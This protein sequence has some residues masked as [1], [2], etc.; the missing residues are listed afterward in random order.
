MKCSR[1][2]Y[3]GS[4]V[5]EMETSLV[6]TT[7][8]LMPLLLK[9]SKTLAMKPTWPSMRV[10]TMSNRVMPFFKTM[11][12]ISS[13]FMSRVSEISVPAASLQHNLHAEM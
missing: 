1:V 3:L 9:M 13:S 7:S 6:A 8:T 11:L 12:V 2:A 10:L 5:R 4:K